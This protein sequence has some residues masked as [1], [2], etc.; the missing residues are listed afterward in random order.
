MNVCEAKLQFSTQTVNPNRILTHK[1]TVASRG[2]EK[3]QPTQRCNGRQ[4]LA[5]MLGGLSSCDE[6]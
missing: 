1:T 6:I 4:A 2:I 5:R 3:L